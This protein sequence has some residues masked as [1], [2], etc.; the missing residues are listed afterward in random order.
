MLDLVRSVEQPFT[1]GTMVGAAERE[2]LSVAGALTW[3]R[4]A[5]GGL[6]TD[7]GARRAS[8]NALRGARLYR[9]RS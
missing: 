4:H 6:V 9:V 1:V 8:E 5:E 3:L 7:T 2:G